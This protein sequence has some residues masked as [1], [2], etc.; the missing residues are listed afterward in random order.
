MKPLT[1]KIIKVHIIC[2]LALNSHPDEV[3]C[4]FLAAAF[5]ERILWTFKASFVSAQRSFR[6]D[7][8]KIDRI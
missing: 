3:K 7:M 6:D 2:T 1:D 5:R 8:L 4:A